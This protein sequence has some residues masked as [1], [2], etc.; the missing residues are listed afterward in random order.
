MMQTNYQIFYTEQNTR[1][2]VMAISDVSFTY[3]LFKTYGSFKWTNHVKV[4]NANL[5][6]I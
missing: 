5:V 3:N 6:Q 2:G 1:L 4:E